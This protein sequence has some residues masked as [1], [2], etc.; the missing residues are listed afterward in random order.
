M[1][2]AIRRILNSNIVV[3]AFCLL[4]QSAILFTK[5]PSNPVWIVY[6]AILL[7]LVTVAAICS[8][9]AH[10][11]NGPRALKFYAWTGMVGILIMTVTDLETAPGDNLPRI[12]MLLPAGAV[13]LT[14]ALDGWIGPLY[15]IATG[16]IL[17]GLGWY[18]GQFNDAIA[19]IAALGILMVP[20]M[21]LA[22]MR[23]EFN[24]LRE[25][26]RAYIHGR[27]D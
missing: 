3:L 17:V 6:T 4:L 9:S 10:N 20:S 25:A 13:S 16:A 21:E 8:W 22:K 24:A 23:D 2:N 7:L 18:Y 15:A 27:T 12:L 26:V 5:G 1:N 14:A 11:G 19:M